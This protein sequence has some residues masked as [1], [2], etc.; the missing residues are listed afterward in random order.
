MGLLCW[1]GEGYAQG[2][3]A[4]LAAQPGRRAMLCAAAGRAGRPGSGGLALLAPQ[5]CVA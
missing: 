1:M 4:G 5:Q 2:A 3:I